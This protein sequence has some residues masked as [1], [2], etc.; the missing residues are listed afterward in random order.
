MQ[1]NKHIRNSSEQ[2]SQKLNKTESLKSNSETLQASK[3]SKKIS[4]PLFSGI[5]LLIVFVLLIG[6]IFIRIEAQSLASK[7]LDSTGQH[8]AAFALDNLSLGGST[9]FSSYTNVDLQKPETCKNLVNTQN[10]ASSGNFAYSGNMYVEFTPTNPAYADKFNYRGLSTLNLTPKDSS[11]QLIL[12]QNVKFDSE[13]LNKIYPSSINNLGQTDFRFK[14]D[15]AADLKNTVTV[16]FTKIFLKNKNGTID[17]KLNG[18]YKEDLKF[19]ETQKQ[20][21]QDLSDLVSELGSTKPE[22]LFSQKS[23]EEIYTYYCSFIE[24]VE[25]KAAQNVDFGSGDSKTTKMVRPLLIT[26]KANG[27]EITKEKLP[28]LLDTISKDQTFISFFKS[29]YDSYV[30][31]LKATDDIFNVK[32]NPI[33]KSEFETNIDSYFNSFNKDEFIKNLT[34][35]DVVRVNGTKVIDAKSLVY[36]DMSNMRVYGFETQTHVIPS[37]RD[38]EEAFTKEVLKDGVKTKLQIFNV[39]HGDDVQKI[40]LPQTDKPVESIVEDLSK[41]QITTEGNKYNPDPQSNIVVNDT[42]TN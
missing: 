38:M 28:A 9:N 4:L 23:L 25:F 32:T 12:D 3:S 17:E 36:F 26:F 20:A 40:E 11:L 24:K 19:S 22:Q 18:P 31:F 10:K 29:K 1:D 34:S 6:G 5:A 35:T 7:I 41:L 37:E 21:I 33:T 14:S 30:K 2:S 27:S 39:K 16:D 8:E 13:V 42:V 15:V